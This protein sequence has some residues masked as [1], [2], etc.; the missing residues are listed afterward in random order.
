V[1]ARRSHPILGTK[2]HSTHHH[3][4]LR[5]SRRYPRR[6]GTGRRG[7]DECAGRNRRM[8]LFEGPSGSFPVPGEGGNSSKFSTQGGLCGV[9][10]GGILNS[11]GRK[12]SRVVELATLSYADRRVTQE[13]EARGATFGP[14]VAGA[15]R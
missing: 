2:V 4:L 5:K 12:I 1:V 13:A 15:G 8:S 11:E 10:P 3:S 14:R 9:G 7:R 6:T